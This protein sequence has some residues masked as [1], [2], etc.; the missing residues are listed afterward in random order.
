MFLRTI[1]IHSI[2]YSIQWKVSGNRFMRNKEEIQHALLAW[3][4]NEKRDL[5]WRRTSDPYRIWI[6]E[7]MLQQTQVETVK[8]YY[9][10]FLKTY[11]TVDTLALGDDDTLMKLWEGLGYYSRAR[12][13]KRAAY[14]LHTEYGGIMP[15]ELGEIRKLPGIGPYTA[16][17]VLSIAYGKAVPA[18]DGNVIRVYSRLF[19]VLEPVDTKEAKET[20]NQIADAL[21]HNGDPGSYNQALMELG[22]MV[23]TP[24]NPKCDTCPVSHCCMALEGGI[25]A[26]LPRKL[27]KKAKKEMDVYAVVLRKEDAFLVV[28]RQSGGLLE[29]LWSLP[30]VEIDRHNEKA[31]DMQSRCLDYLKDNFDMDAVFSEELGKAAHVFTHIK[32]H[33]HVVAFEW[34]SGEIPAF[35]E[36]M[37]IKASEIG[38]YA[39]PTAYKKALRSA[40]LL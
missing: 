34:V 40:S 19:S 21:V 33:I 32:W 20:I 5:P 6:S 24:R 35:P 4:E 26:E 28:R 25:Q 15:T 10:R 29:G 3:Y 2:A 7:V 12:N 13:L 27:P 8:G 30:S 9:E 22:A 39:F 16:G 1:T 37:W 17:A 14:L 38:T 36:S 11:P 18:V 31:A 23:C